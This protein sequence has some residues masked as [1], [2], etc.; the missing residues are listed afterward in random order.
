MNN[1]LDL[2]AYFV[3]GTPGTQPITPAEFP[4]VAAIA[5]AA[6]R[7][8]CGVVQVRSKPLSVRDLT[9][10]AVQVAAAVAEANPATRVLIDDRVDVAAALM[11]S[12]HIHGVHVGQDD[13]DPRLARKVLGEDAIIGLTTGTLELVRGAGDY[14]DVLDYIGCGPFK[15][16][17]T[18]DSGRPPIGLE[19]YPAL[20][21]ASRLPMVAIGGVTAADAPALAATGVDGVAIVRGFMHADDPQALAAQIVADFAQATAHNATSTAGGRP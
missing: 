18:K 6:A 4:R 14:A 8:G 7:G 21:A 2:R 11:G 13:L 3:T 10:L 16:T 12:H 1:T 5:A 19:G 9:E 15:P 20:V 17:P